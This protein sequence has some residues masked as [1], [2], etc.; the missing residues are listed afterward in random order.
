[1]LSWLQTT[2][3]AVSKTETYSNS[4][5]GTSLSFAFTV[6]T[7][8][9]SSSA[10]SQNWSETYSSSTASYRTLRGT[11]ETINTTKLSDG[12]AVPNS[13]SGR[14]TITSTSYIQTSTA[15]E[16]TNYNFTS[17]TTEEQ[18]ISVWTTSGPTSEP[19][20]YQ[21]ETATTITT[22][23]ITEKTFLE[24]GTTEDTLTIYDVPYFNS[25]YQATPAGTNLLGDFAAEVLFSAGTTDAA[26]MSSEATVWPASGTR[27]TAPFDAPLYS[28]T[29]STFGAPVTNSALTDS[30]TYSAV[31]NVPAGTITVCSFDR[32]FPQQTRTI[33]FRTSISTTA[34]TVNQTYFQSQEV[35][36]PTK[37]TK[38][39][40]ASFTKRTAW[41]LGSSYEEVYTI[42]A[43]RTAY[44]ADA[45]IVMASSD[46][47]E[48]Y[49]GISATTLHD[50][51]LAI[52]TSIAAPQAVEANSDGLVPLRVVYGPYG[53]S[54]DGSIGAA[55]TFNGIT[56]SIF[57]PNSQE[58]YEALGGREAPND[59]T[60]GSV[61]VLRPGYYTYSFV[62]SS[63][64]V[65]I[66]GE[67]VSLTGTS[68]GTG[69]D[70][71]YSTVGTASVYGPSALV[72]RNSVGTPTAET[73]FGAEKLNLLGYNIIGGGLGPSETAVELIPRGFWNFGSGASF[74]EG[75]VTTRSDS[76]ATSVGFP[77]T[78]FGPE[79]ATV[80]R[81][82]N[83]SPHLVW[84]ETATSYLPF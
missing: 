38:Q 15:L 80:T 39:W 68:S 5:S 11:D 71:T 46:V 40:F 2:S 78:Y 79:L 36:L 66:S 4:K 57:I 48:S 9:F 58:H 62:D 18:L 33:V 41:Q 51:P 28:V 75:S 69:T 12:S 64:S 47:D 63:V 42:L 61:Y 60:S 1:M 37:T 56:E 53:R 27:F 29:G 32:S 82:T 22:S 34:Q 7:T 10:A 52:A 25:I 20:F 67:T 19:V 59:N 50:V 13:E 26:A 24:Y 16:N 73:E 76:V 55:F 21:T 14:S 43:S 72:R 65:S 54:V 17:T 70:S 74:Y 49:R 31:A 84:A 81:G 83:Q 45:K 3:A 35:A 23:T 77:V 44:A 8:S 30:F 6:S